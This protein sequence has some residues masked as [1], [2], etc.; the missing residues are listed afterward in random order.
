LFDSLF[1]WGGGGIV[2]GTLG[3]GVLGSFA[4]RLKP[5]V[6]MVQRWA[7][8]GAIYVGLFGATMVLA[9]KMSL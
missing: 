8:R 9:S 6:D 5:E 1:K 3:G 4:E 7:V 2:L